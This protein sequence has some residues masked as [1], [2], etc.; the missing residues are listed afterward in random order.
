MWPDR[1]RL[2]PGFLALPAAVRFQSLGSLLTAKAGRNCS[3]TSFSCFA[4]LLD[5]ARYNLLAARLGEYAS[6]APPI[7]SGWHHGAITREMCCCDIQHHSIL[8]L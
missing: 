2:L 8:A 3:A 5:F 4:A 7:W 6:R 1:G